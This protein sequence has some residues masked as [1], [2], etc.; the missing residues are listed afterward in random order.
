MQCYAVLSHHDLQVIQKTQQLFQP[1][2]STLLPPQKKQTEKVEWKLCKKVI[3][4][5]SEP[6]MILEIFVGRV[7]IDVCFA[8]HMGMDWLQL[9]CFTNL[10]NNLFR[11]QQEH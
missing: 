6:L 5:S 3:K 9:D 1:F 11:Q 4:C 8:R 2:T 10:E 7:Q